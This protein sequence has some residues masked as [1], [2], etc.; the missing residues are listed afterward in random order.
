MATFFALFSRCIIVVTAT[1]ADPVADAGEPLGVGGGVG[2]DE[3]AGLL[4]PVAE[5]PERVVAVVAAPALP[6]S[7]P[8]FA[9]AA[10]AHCH[11]P[12]LDRSI[13]RGHR[14]RRHKPQPPSLSLSIYLFSH[15]T[16]TL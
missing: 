14:R 12:S 16:H 5:G 1:G 9:A 13:D 2:V 6:V 11:R 15:A 4:A 8:T 7:F 10:A 3:E